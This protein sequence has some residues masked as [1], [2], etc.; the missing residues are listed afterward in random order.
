MKFSAKTQARI[1]A[2]Y[3]SGT[4]TNNIGSQL[5]F[6]K[7]YAS[8]VLATHH[9]PLRYRRTT[10][11]EAAAMAALYKKGTSGTEI[12]KRFC[13]TPTAVYAALDRLGIPRRPPYNGFLGDCNHDFFNVI[14]SELK[15]YF[16]G[17]MAGDGCVSEANEIIFSLQHADIALVE[18]FRS[19]LEIGNAVRTGETEKVFEGHRFRYTAARVSV[20]SCVLAKALAKFGVI[21]AK[22]GRTR[23]AIIPGEVPSR[24]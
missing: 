19:A 6:H 24:L 15:A 16:L 20:N 21:P 12:A 1:I 17:A 14:D 4:S 18:T 5:G 23:P 8:K 2:M 11:S 10:Q 7:S 13:T 22:T 3:Q 9:I